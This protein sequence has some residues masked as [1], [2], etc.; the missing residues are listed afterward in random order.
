MTVSIAV[1]VPAYNSEDT[2]A[3]CLLSILSQ[4]FPA[5]Q[6]IVVDDGS[7]DAT[8]QVA[9]QFG[10]A[11]HFIRQENQGSAGARDTGS[12]AATTDYIAYLDADDW[13]PEDRLATCQQLLGKEPI[14]FLIADLQR[15]RHGDSP[16]A[17]LPRN[18][19]FFPWIQDYF[20]G[21]E[22]LSGEPDLY[23]FAPEVALR[24][25]LRGFPVYPSTMLVRRPAVEA[26]GSWDRRFK[27]AQD[28]DIALRLSRRFPLYY[29]HRMQ[30]VLGLH[31]GN[32][33]ASPYVIKQTRGDIEVL[34]AH[35]EAELPGSAYHRQ[36]ARALARK[37]CGL[38]YTY[39]KSGDRD[40]ARAA[41]LQALCWPGRRMHALLRWLV[42]W[43]PSSR[44]MARLL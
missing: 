42:L 9:E 23:R 16:N 24:I 27:R 14:D 4:T 36:V 43:V 39:R 20:A 12:R 25:L 5:Q 22:A 35:L 15:A 40:E 21:Q 29:Y 32:E 44:A 18:S 11:I 1:V 26:V 13:W 2:L 3:S 34:R 8:A 37:Y 6:I 10:D 17:Y 7:R 28:F 38:A 33:D 31:S 30:A 41:Y 19:S